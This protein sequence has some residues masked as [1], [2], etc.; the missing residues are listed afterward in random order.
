MTQEMKALLEAKDSP[1]KGDPVFQERL[2]YLS[3][4]KNRQRIHLQKELNAFLKKALVGYMKPYESVCEILDI[5]DFMTSYLNA[6]FKGDVT[7]F[8]L[9]THR[10]KKKRSPG[11]NLTHSHRL[12]T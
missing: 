5:Q 1:L 7:N 9:H 11:M 10:T 2:F 8:A 6:S 3:S 12:L 4:Q